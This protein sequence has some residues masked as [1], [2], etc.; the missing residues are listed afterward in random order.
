MN[1]AH[2]LLRARRSIRR[3]KPEPVPEAALDRILTTAI[4]APSAH[5]RQPWRFA[6]V[7]T[8][9][10]RD[11]LA[12]GLIDKMQTDMRAEGAVEL[13]IQARAANSRRRIREAPLIVVLC[14]DITD[15]RL[16]TRE[17]ALMAVQSVAAAGLQLLLAAQA[18]GLG[19]NWICWPLY[20]REQT[21]F[22]LDLPAN[23]EPQ[24]M[25]I[26]GTPAEKPKEKQLKPLTEVVRYL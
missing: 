18:E 14:R 24:A 11:R 8:P 12:A 20:A 26:I 1:P 6:V 4:H 10:L 17:E 25:L 3:F 19:G 15:V 22:A 5:N 16:D 2:E 9:A 21:R 23:W 7:Q 13:E